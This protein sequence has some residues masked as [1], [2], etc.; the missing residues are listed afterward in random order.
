MATCINHNGNIIPADEQIFKTSNRTFLYGDGIFESIKVAYGKPVN[1]EAH[2]NRLTKGATTL[3]IELPYNMTISCFSQ[4][5]TELL[6]IND[7]LP[8][9]R[10]RFTLYR[11][12]GG[13]YQPTTNKGMYVIESSPLQN[14]NFIL[15]SKGL[16]I[17][18]YEHI[19]K[20][21]SLISELKSCNALNYVMAKMFATQKNL[22][23]CL[24]LNDQ[25][26]IVEAT[27]SNIFV[28]KKNNI[29]TPPL[30]EGCVDGT[31]RKLIIKTIKK[32]NLLF[33]EHPINSDD[34]IDGDEVFLSNAISGIKWVLN[35]KQKHFS[36]KTSVLLTE[37]LNKLSL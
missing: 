6:K 19:K 36:N 8:A 23:D 13:L 2:Y 26:N 24:I 30:E 35:Y 16:T 31:M 4:Q 20:M 5:I 21:P 32:T 18:T 11:A 10:V 15:N 28:V 17:D 34:L 29:S 12:D 7:H 9:A 3:K 1:I 14:N 27:S 25:K 22:D 33:N 37:R